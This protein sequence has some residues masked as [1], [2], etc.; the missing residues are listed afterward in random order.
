M[1]TLNVATQTLWS[2]IDSRDLK[3]DNLMLE[4]SREGAEIIVMD[5]G[6]GEILHTSQKLEDASGTLPYMAPGI[7]LF[8]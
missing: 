2:F 1:S 3:L 4:N 6:L 7:A 5:F 8:L